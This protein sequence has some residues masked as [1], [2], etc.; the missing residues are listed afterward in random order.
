KLPTVRAALDLRSML[1]DL[2]SNARD[3]ENLPWDI[4]SWLHILQRPA[5]TPTASGLMNCHLGWIAYHAQRRALV[6]LLTARF[7]VTALS[8]LWREPSLWS[9]CGRRLVAVVAVLVEL[10]FKPLDPCFVFFD[11][12]QKRLLQIIDQRDDGI[13]PSPI[14][15]ENLL[16]PNARK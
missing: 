16:A 6:S 10:L 14:S 1:G 12:S 4:A 15:V 5:A 9:I 7:L 11:D 8:I 13:R 2:H 3:I